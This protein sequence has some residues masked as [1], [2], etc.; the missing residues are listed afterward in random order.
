MPSIYR[1]R[2]A[3]APL[4]LSAA[5]GT[6]RVASQYGEI[7]ACFERNFGQSDASTV[8]LASGLGC[9]LAL[10][11]KG[12]TLSLAGAPGPHY[13]FGSDPGHWITGVQQFGKVPY[14][15]VCPGIDLLWHVAARVSDRRPA[16]PRA[17]F[18]AP[19]GARDCN[20]VG[21]LDLQ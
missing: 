18:T 12:A 13:Y 1:L 6:A 10:T 8:Y 20:G 3:L 2:I 14:R 4:V 11:T 9:S 17:T 16:L 19:R 7:P 15:N 21:G 5:P